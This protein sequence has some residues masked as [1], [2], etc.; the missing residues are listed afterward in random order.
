M[1]NALHYSYWPGEESAPK[2]LYTSNSE[3]WKL[4]RV[5]KVRTWTPVS[6]FSGSGLL[7]ATKLYPLR[8]LSSYHSDACF[9]N[10]G[11]FQKLWY[12]LFYL[13]QICFEKRIFT[14]LFLYFFL[15]F[16]SITPTLSGK[17]AAGFNSFFHEIAHMSHSQCQI[18]MSIC[19]D[20]MCLRELK[21]PR[22]L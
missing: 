13:P 10:T 14:F 7:N 18:R 4:T 3:A 20:F 17:V 6:L 1:K 2:E 9:I 12:D 16:Y 22:N 5:P 11:Y 19:L 15:L 8:V 21:S